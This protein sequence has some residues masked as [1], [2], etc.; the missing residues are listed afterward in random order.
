M[1]S[2]LTRPD[3][4]KMQLEK[5]LSN[6]LKPFITFSSMLFLTPNYL[7]SYI[8]AIGTFVIFSYSFFRFF[9]YSEYKRKDYEIK[10]FQD[11]ELKT[12]IVYFK[13]GVFKYLN[14]FIAFFGFV[15]QHIE[16]KNFFLLFIVFNLFTL[17]NITYARLHFFLS[18]D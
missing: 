2:W 11:H 5:G 18:Y 7:K 13:R 6:F 3:M 14:Y 16:F 15:W 8:L 17:I 9:Y 10:Y 12:T 4:L 1:S